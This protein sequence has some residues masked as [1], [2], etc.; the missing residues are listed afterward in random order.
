MADGCK[1]AGRLMKRKNHPLDFC[2]PYLRHRDIEG[3]SRY[4]GEGVTLAKE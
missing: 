2:E 1:E 3:R 4:H